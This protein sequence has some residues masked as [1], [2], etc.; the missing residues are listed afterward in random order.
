MP[1]DELPRSV[2]AHPTRH[3]A[4]YHKFPGLGADDSRSSSRQHLLI[5]DQEYRIA[6]DDVFRNRAFE[7][8][9]LDKAVLEEPENLRFREDKVFV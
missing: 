8:F 9:E 7:P 6:F 1:R 3:K 4:R 2:F 5:A